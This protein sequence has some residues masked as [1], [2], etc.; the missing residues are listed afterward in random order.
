MTWLWNLLGYNEAGKPHVER[1][2]KWPKLRAEH[3]KREPKCAVCGKMDNAT[4]H[5][6]KPVHLFPE[7]EL[8]QDNLITLCEGKAQNDHLIFG[9]LSNWASFNPLVR[10]DAIVWRFK[11]LNRPWKRDD[12][13][14]QETSP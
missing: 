7:L 11:I 4:P 3:L 14:S 8:D 5:H 2:S 12:L 1:S 9:H 6:V 13:P 10:L